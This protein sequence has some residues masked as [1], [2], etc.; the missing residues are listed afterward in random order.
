MRTV[1]Q[2]VFEYKEEIWKY[3]RRSLHL[4]HAESVL[5]NFNIIHCLGSYSL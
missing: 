4:D 3:K 5:F 2:L 1:M